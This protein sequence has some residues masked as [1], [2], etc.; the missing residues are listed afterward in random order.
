[1]TGAKPIEVG[2]KA[3]II[4]CSNYPHR[5]GSIV[6]VIGDL[7]IWT[8]RTVKMQ[9]W[10]TD[11]PGPD[12]GTADKNLMRIDDPDIQKQIEQETKIPVFVKPGF[13]VIYK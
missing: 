10:N 9:A 12:S 4:E 13:R 11:M 6:T 2:C 8:Y 5:V 1:M 7:G 3:M